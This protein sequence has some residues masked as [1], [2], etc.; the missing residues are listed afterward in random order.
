MNE[1]SMF[2]LEPSEAPPRDAA[3]PT[4]WQC[5]GRGVQCLGFQLT[6]DWGDAWR[7]DV[8]PALRGSLIPERATD[9]ERLDR[10]P[11]S[12]RMMDGSGASRRNT[13][14]FVETIDT[15]V[16]GDFYHWSPGFFDLFTDGL[17]D[18]HPPD[19]FTI[20]LGEQLLR[21]CAGPRAGLS[22]V[23]AYLE[24]LGIHVT[25]IRPTRMELTADFLIEGAIGF[26]FLRANAPPGPSLRQHELCWSPQCFMLEQR[27]PSAGSGMQIYQRLPSDHLAAGGTIRR[28][29][30][31]DQAEHVWCVRSWVDE[32]VLRQLGI[33]TAETALGP[34]PGHVWRWATTQG[35][36]LRAPGPSPWTDRP[37][38]PW[39][40]AVRDAWGA[41]GRCRTAYPQMHTP[42]SG[43]V[44]AAASTT[45]GRRA[46]HT[47]SARDVTRHIESQ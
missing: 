10:P 29:L 42:A 2:N 1:D 16:D 39:W 32:P 45:A 33:D 11:W 9:A 5:I 8:E 40:E 7:R 20:Y 22:L 47:A 17:S 25:A 44:A 36:S 4:S 34:G 6:A 14:A 37:L 41:T 12:V 23:E 13:R 21:T 28:R 3:G 38:H 27:Q 19:S 18:D 43:R 24:D 31:A 35:F 15:R 30:Q 46:G 26:D